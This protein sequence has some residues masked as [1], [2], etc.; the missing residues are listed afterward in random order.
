VSL[1]I[2][3]AKR[4]TKGRYHTLAKKRV[5]SFQHGTPYLIDT[6]EKEDFANYYENQED[7][8][9]SLSLLDS[10]RKLEEQEKLITNLVN[11]VTGLEEKLKLKDDEVAKKIK[12]KDDEVETTKNNLI[13][14][15][16]LLYEEKNP[17]FIEKLFEEIILKKVKEKE[18][19]I[20][21]RY[22]RILSQKQIEINRLMRKSN[23]FHLPKR[24]GKDF[25]SSY[26]NKCPFCSNTIH[27]GDA[28]CK[29]RFQNG[30]EKFVHS[31]CCNN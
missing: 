6:W 9:Y 12:Q 10:Q 19:E 4:I 5:R 2:S 11:C 21:D 17:I 24:I 16:Q 1:K 20:A 31:N 23:N 15:Y 26:T 3:I 22:K 29:A 14:K 25:A 13:K 30:H 8:K 27:I 28:I 18:I 7:K